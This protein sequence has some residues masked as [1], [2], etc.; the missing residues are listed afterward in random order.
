MASRLY[1]LNYLTSGLLYLPSGIGGLI[2]SLQTGKLLDYNYKVV[3]R[4]LEL[5]PSTNCNSTDIPVPVPSPPAS[6]SMSHQNLCAFPIERARASAP[7]CLFL[8]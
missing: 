6:V 4:G 8:G 5:S 3:A 1:D 7:S 2:A